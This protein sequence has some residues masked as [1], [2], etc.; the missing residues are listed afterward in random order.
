MRFASNEYFCEWEKG[1]LENNSKMIIHQDVWGFAY[2]YPQILAHF[3]S[4]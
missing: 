2:I 4:L 1:A 3:I